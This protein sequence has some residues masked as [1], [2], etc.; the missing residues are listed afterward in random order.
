MLPIFVAIIASMPG[1]EE[2][3]WFPDMYS[4]EVTN[5]QL[6]DGENLNNHATQQVSQAEFEANR[7]YVCG[8]L[9]N[10]T[11]GK[12][13]RPYFYMMP[14]EGGA[15][16][17]KG[18]VFRF[19]KGDFFVPIKGVTPEVGTYTLDLYKA[20]DILYSIEFQVVP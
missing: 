19:E 8:H 20:K 15:V 17:H 12:A 7:V 2:V 18:E 4:I 13:A 16:W 1:F 9:L 3:E 6:C 5:L 10:L 14:E 11:P